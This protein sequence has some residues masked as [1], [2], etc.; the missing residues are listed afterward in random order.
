MFQDHVHLQCRGR[1]RGTNHHVRVSLPRPS[2]LC[3]HRQVPTTVRRNVLRKC[4]RRFDSGLPLELER[5][6]SRTFPPGTSALLRP[7]D[8]ETPSEPRKRM[9]SSLG[10]GVPCH[11][12]CLPNAE[13]V[14]TSPRLIDPLAPTYA[15]K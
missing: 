4:P 2:P 6:S 3:R 10:S 12:R 1:G 8:I 15:Q 9:R 7:S 5:R 13:Q 11:R 14:L